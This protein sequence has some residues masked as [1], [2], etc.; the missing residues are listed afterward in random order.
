M[1]INMIVESLSKD[2]LKL[3]TINFFCVQRICRTVFVMLES[4]ETTSVK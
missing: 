1:M 2:D 3:T 4:Y